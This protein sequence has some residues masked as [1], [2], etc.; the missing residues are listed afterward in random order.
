MCHAPIL[1]PGPGRHSMTIVGLQQTLDLAYLTQWN[2]IIIFI[3]SIDI[4]KLEKDE[5]TKNV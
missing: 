3:T 5:I 4:T 1:H 2:T